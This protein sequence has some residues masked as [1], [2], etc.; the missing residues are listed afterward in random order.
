MLKKYSFISDLRQQVM[1]SF[2]LSNRCVVH[3]KSKDYINA[4]DFVMCIKKSA[5]IW[6]L[7][8]IVYI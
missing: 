6:F 5:K 7:V 3:K 1:I 8:L 4:I 2:V